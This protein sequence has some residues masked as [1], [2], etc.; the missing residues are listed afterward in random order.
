MSDRNIK[1]FMEINSGTESDSRV[2]VAEGD[3]VE[4]R[5]VTEVSQYPPEHVKTF[6]SRWPKKTVATHTLTWKTVTYG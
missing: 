2:F 5:M 3:S 6:V 1:V 4:Y